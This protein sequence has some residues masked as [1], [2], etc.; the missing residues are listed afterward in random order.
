MGESWVIG[1][2]MTADGACSIFRVNP[3][4][5]DLGPGSAYRTALH[6]VVSYEETDDV[7]MPTVSTSANLRQFEDRIV[8]GLQ[9]GEESVL[10]A[11][12]TTPERGRT[13]CFYTTA[14][15]GLTALIAGAL[16]PYG[17]TCQS[18]QQGDDPEWRLYRRQLDHAREGAEDMAVVKKLESFGID[19]RRQR[20]VEHVL[21]FDSQEN[22]RRVLAGPLVPFETSGPDD[23]GDGVWGVVVRVEQTVEFAPLAEKRRWFKAICSDFDG[24]YDGWGTPIEQGPEKARRRPRPF[25]R[26]TGIR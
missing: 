13:F 22:A 21:L 9:E 14:V 19:P 3:G 25:V 18:F 4:L 6:V 1:V 17:G 20:T 26:R 24:S 8:A 7:G 23:L 15:D 16:A 10:A 2:A 12:V 11:V 5:R